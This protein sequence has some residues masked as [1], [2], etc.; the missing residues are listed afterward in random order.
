M[1]RN[2]TVT[3][4]GTGT[5]IY[6]NKAKVGGHTTKGTVQLRVYGGKVQVVTTEG[7][8]GLAVILLEKDGARILYDGLRNF[9]G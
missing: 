2:A 3:V 7:D 4:P 5:T 6:A 9:L 1:V 8:K